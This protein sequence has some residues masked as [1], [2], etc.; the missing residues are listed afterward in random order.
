[1][2]RIAARQ[3][4]L[5]PEL[6]V[7]SARDSA[8][9][10]A[11]NILGN[12]SDRIA[13]DLDIEPLDATFRDSGA[14]PFHSW[15]PYL[16]GY[17]PRFVRRVRSAYLPA[18]RHVLE[19]FAGSG[20]TPI[21]LGQ[22]GIACSYAEANPAMALVSAA[23]LNAMAPGTDRKLLSKQLRALAAS[24]PD[25]LR[26]VSA[27]EDLRSSYASAFGSSVFFT[28]DGLERV[29]RL[30]AVGTTIEAEADATVS[31]CFNVAV[32]SALIPS[33]LLKRAGD[34]RYRT[35]KELLQPLPDAIRL[36]QEKLVLMAGDVASIAPSSAPSLF[37]VADARQ[38]LQMPNTLFDG[39]ITSPP[40]LN[41]TNYIRN[42]RLELWYLR[43]L[44]SK[45]HLRQLR[46]CVVTS[47]INDVDRN[48]PHASV[49]AGVE[50]VV[51]R[52]R[53]EAYD[54]RIAKMVGG[55]FV[56]MREVLRGIGSLV[57]PG[58][59]VCVDIGDSLYAGVHVPTDEL[60][61]EIG[62]D[63]GFDLADKVYLR[64]RRS[65]GGDELRQTLLVFRKPFAAMQYN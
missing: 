50:K 15:F 52:L 39:V 63:L 27:D 48:T 28:P 34:L 11:T 22:D 2:S 16:E 8:V 29:L 65:K 47:G 31:D 14:A 36:V 6:E 53:A 45:R 56:D 5:F 20:T 23:K 40:Y 49:S 35:P 1:M 9:P 7:V 13:A 18:A 51:S 60:L 59:A 37:L 19:P 30:R 42:A 38:L 26:C 3:V 61:V 10:S 62:L 58:V 24:L 33:S 32:M 43:R 64:K 12:L 21:V 54:D 4:S 57:K 25:R 44:S 17:S 46:D 55:Y 41:G